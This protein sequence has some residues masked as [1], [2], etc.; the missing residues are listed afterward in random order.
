MMVE[1]MIR[2]EGEI[3]SM[4]NESSY[5]YAHELQM[6]VLFAFLESCPLLSFFLTLLYVVF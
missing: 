1:G 3:R 4:D 2:G 5:A 6:N